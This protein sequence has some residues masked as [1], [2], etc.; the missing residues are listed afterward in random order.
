MRA[1]LIILG[2]L[3][4]WSS[5]HLYVFRKSGKVDF[6]FSNGDFD[7]VWIDSENNFFVLKGT[8]RWAF[9]SYLYALITFLPVAKSLFLFLPSCLD[10]IQLFV[11]KKELFKNKWNICS[12][13][14]IKRKGPS[15]HPDPSNA[16]KG[17]GKKWPNNLIASN[18]KAESG[19]QQPLLEL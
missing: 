14:M 12:L 5:A 1:S 7:I 2:R 16:V 18:T 3:R 19:C 13:F 10:I 4:N 11:F 8:W 17:P 9:Y 15:G 6:I